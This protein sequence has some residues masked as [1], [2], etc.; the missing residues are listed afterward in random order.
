M[1]LH[2]RK[3]NTKESISHIIT[4]F[5]I[6]SGD[7][8]YVKKLYACVYGVALCLKRKKKLISQYECTV[9]IPNIIV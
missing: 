6:K 1:H 3:K 9:N 7:G 8:S 2:H 5:Y 4:A